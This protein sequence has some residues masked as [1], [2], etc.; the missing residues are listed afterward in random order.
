MTPLQRTLARLRNLFGRSRWEHW[1]ITE[2]DEERQASGLRFDLIDASENEVTALHGKP[3]LIESPS[4]Q[5]FD[6]EGNVT[7]AVDRGLVYDDLLRRTRVVFYIFQGR[8]HSI[9]FLPKLKRCPPDVAETAGIY[10]SP[11]ETHVEHS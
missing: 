7:F 9:S 8:V 3:T 6:E 4:L 1:D 2:C 11:Q 5:H 10:Y